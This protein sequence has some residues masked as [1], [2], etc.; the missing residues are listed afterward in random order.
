MRERVLE[1]ISLQEKKA[2]IFYALKEIGNSTTPIIAGLIGI[3]KALEFSDRL[4]AQANYFELPMSII[5]LY[6]WANYHVEQ[7]N[8]F[9]DTVSRV[10]GPL[11]RK[12]SPD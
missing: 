7:T 4:T 12:K 2:Y 11:R 3:A 10:L 9:I 6:F 8:I 5:F 1:N